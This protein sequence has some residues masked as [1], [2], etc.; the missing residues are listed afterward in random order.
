MKHNDQR[1]KPK[2]KIK[3]VN[4]VMWIDF[5]QGGVYLDI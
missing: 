4:K 5:G 1:D 3:L 2:R